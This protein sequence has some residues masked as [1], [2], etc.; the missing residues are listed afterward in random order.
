MI[1]TIRRLTFATCLLCI[2]ASCSSAGDNAAANTDAASTARGT[3][4]GDSDGDSD[5]DSDEDFISDS[6]FETDPDT[7]SSVDTESDTGTGADTDSDTDTASDEDTYSDR[8]TDTVSDVDSDTVFAVETDT[9]S[10]TDTQRSS[11]KV[12]AEELGAIDKC[13]KTA[14]PESFEPNVQWSWVGGTSMVTPLVANLTDDNGDGEI[15]LCDI[16]DIVVVAL[17]EGDG[18]IFVLDGAAGGEHYRTD[19]A[20]D[21]TVTPAIGD[22]DGDGLAEIVT[23]VKYGHLIA[24]EHDGTFKWQSSDEWTSAFSGQYCGSVGLADLDQD[25]DVEIITGNIVW[26]HEG[27]QQWIAGEPAGYYSATTAADLDG[28]PGLELVLGHAAY[29][30][31][32]SP[33]YVNTEV[34]PGFPQVAD[35]DSDG[36]PEV[37]VTNHDGISMLDHDGTTR[38]V[39]LTPVDTPGLILDWIRPATIHDFDGDGEVEFAMSA[40]IWYT[41]YESDG[42]IVWKAEVSDESGIAAGTAFDFLGDGTAEAMYADEDTMFIFDETGAV[43]LSTGRTSGTLVE[44]P[45]VADVDN[46]GSAEI[47]VVSQGYPTVQVIRDVEDRWIQARRIW[48]QHTYHVTNV[49]EDGTIPQV[50]PK[51]WELFNTFR[52]NIQIENGSLC[53]TIPPM[54]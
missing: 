43:L 40:G 3:S 32:G 41:V 28:E 45:V 52:T 31:D 46:D 42:T 37:L 36:L 6:D 50:E 51:S 7:H 29:H 34:A 14:P 25:G 44:Y 26:D 23:A 4:D 38:F 16:P 9:E 47:V 54:V 22:I 20:V 17:L 39:N 15:D 11:C 18:R 24:F 10:T 2:P 12:P 21:P 48:N 49:R 53:N 1:Q 27:E 13:T 5:S 30:A 19:V 33:Y 8:D 35:M